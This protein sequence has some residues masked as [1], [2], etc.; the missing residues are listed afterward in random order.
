VLQL[1]GLLRPGAERRFIQRTTVHIK[2]PNTS[3]ER[4]CMCVW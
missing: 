4:L 3:R 2:P 1:F